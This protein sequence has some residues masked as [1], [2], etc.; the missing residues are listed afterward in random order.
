MRYGHWYHFSNLDIVLVFFGNEL[1][2]TGN[3]ETGY[4]IVLGFQQ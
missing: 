1:K 3:C 2:I 4:S